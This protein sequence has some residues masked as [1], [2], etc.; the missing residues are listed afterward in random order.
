MSGVW[1]CRDEA[2][3]V[4]GGGNAKKAVGKFGPDEGVWEGSGVDGVPVVVRQ[5]SSEEGIPLCDDSGMLRW[6]YC[7]LFL[8]DEL[9]K[10]GCEAGGVVEGIM[11]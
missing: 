9:F 5:L 10:T 4:R 1:C 7:K 2:E 6:L 3:A 11:G 8:I